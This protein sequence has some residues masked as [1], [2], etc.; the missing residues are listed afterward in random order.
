VFLLA[1]VPPPLRGVVRR[2]VAYD[3]SSGPPVRRRQA[4]TGTATLVLGLGEPLRVDDRPLGSFLAGL[5]DTVAVTEFRGHQAGVQVDL[6]PLGLMRLLGA[7]GQEVSG[8]PVVV[9]D[10][11]GVCP[12][13]RALAVLSARVGELPS[14]SAR[15]ALVTDTLTELL[16][17]SA[18]A[19][20][21]EVAHA[22]R[23]LAA[24][25]GRVPVPLLAAEVGWSRRHLSRRFAA[26]VGLAP[27]TTARVLRFRRAADLL[28]P[29]TGEPAARPGRIADVAG[30]CGYA[31]HAHLDREFR[32]L[33]GCSPQDYV[34]E[35]AAVGVEAADVVRT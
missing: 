27:T 21:P 12:A 18:A 33:A 7:P 23:R 20:D 13:G 17:D 5:S 24:A 35:W 25:R 16:A 9:G 6:A 19:P 30:E 2:L 32:A 22:W 10:L 34:T 1:A 15:L 4:P 29:G 8:A 14:W 28:V 26:Q 11:A 3:E 31:D